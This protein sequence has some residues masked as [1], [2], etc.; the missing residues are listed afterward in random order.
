MTKITT[1]W[2][3]GANSS[4]QSF[5]YLREHCGFENEYCVNYSSSSRFYNN[6]QQI[7]E[8]TKTLGPVFLVGHSLGGLYGIHLTKY[9]NVVGGVSISTPFGGS[10]TADWAKYVVPNY[11][12]FRDIG[13]RSRPVVEGLEIQLNIPWT[14]VV[15]TKGNVPYHGAINDGV[16]TIDSMTARNDVETIHVPYTHYEVVCNQQVVGIVKDCFYRLTK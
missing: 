3:H 4:S 1:V 12:L 14:Q 10:F 13:L 9:V 15:S 7:I 2:I 16:V 5:E 8:E 6:L 11:P